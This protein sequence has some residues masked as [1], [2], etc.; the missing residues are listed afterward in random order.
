MTAQV[1]VNQIVKKVKCSGKKR[2]EIHRQLLADIQTEIGQGVP[3]DVIMLRMG[4]PIAIAE[5]FNQNL[6]QQEYRKYKRGFFAKLAAGI[7]AVIAVLIIIAVWFLSIG[8]PFG[9]SG[10]YTQAEVEARSKE[11]IRLL[12]AG[13]YEALRAGA[14]DHMQ[15]ILT[16]E[17]IGPAKKL[18][19][20]DWGEFREFGKCYLSEQ[21]TRGKTRAVAQINAAYENIGITYTLFFNSDLKL[22]GLYIK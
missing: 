1:Y 6:S 10:L 18:A 8:L 5:E 9:T 3:L 16:E 15:N 20:M 19:G 12:D 2:K 17:T 22:S 4:E 14:A 13:D 7:V 11:V 21:W